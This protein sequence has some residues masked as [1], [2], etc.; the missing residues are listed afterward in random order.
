MN[1]EAIKELSEAMNRLAKA[2]EGL[3]N[4]GASPGIS[5][6]LHQIPYSPPHYPSQ[7]Y[8]GPTVWG[9][10]CGTITGGSGGMTS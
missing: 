6:Y 7:P 8:Y 1:D 4:G 5:I 2:I 10:G 3:R 9:G